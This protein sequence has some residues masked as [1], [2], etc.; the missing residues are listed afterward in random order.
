MRRLLRS[1]LA[2]RL[3]SGHGMGL[4]HAYRLRAIRMG[5][6]TRSRGHEQRC[7]EVCH[8]RLREAASGAS[9]MTRGRSCPCGTATDLQPWSR[10][11]I[12]AATG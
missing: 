1:H 5:T 8:R 7:A 10:V 2:G 3:A 6:Y 11:L 9:P 4:L 12:C